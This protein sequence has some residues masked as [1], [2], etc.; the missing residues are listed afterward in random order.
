[1][2]R[3]WWAEKEWITQEHGGR[4]MTHHWSPK[5]GNVHFGIMHCYT[6]GPTSEEISSW[7]R[8]G[9]KADS[10]EGAHVARLTLHDVYRMCKYVFVVHLTEFARL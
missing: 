10:M 8:G 4:A 2:R 7:T 6:R 1:M 3:T 5:V 9:G